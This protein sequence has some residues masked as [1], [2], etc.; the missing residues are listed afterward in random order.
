MDPTT[1]RRAHDGPS[2]LGVVSPNSNPPRG[3]FDLSHS[4][5]T[6]SYVVLTL[7]HHILVSLNLET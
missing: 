3:L 4:V 1:G 5:K 2:V 7:N 6:L